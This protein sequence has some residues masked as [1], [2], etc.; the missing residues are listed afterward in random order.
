MLR[1]F[2][3]EFSNPLKIESAIIKCPI[4]NSIISFIDT[5]APTLS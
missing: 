4:F 3:I 2:K 1:I 5:I